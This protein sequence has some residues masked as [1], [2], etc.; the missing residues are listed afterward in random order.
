MGQVTGFTA[1]ACSVPWR[2]DACPASRQSRAERYVL[3]KKDLNALMEDRVQAALL[4]EWAA[5]AAAAPLSRADAKIER[6][7]SVDTW[8]EEKEAWMLKP[9]TAG[10]P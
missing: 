8:K 10:K 5:P 9:G 7:A 4:E 2:T 6:D 3:S 1:A